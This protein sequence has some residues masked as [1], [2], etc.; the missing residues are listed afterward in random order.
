[1]SAPEG[2]LDTKG[3]WDAAA[4]FP[5]QVE[6]AAAQTHSLIGLP[7]HD[8]IEN[9]VVLGMGG[10][11]IA[12]DLMTAL[13]GPFMPVPIVVTKGYEPPSFVGPQTLC[14]ALSF[15]GDTEETIEAAQTAA[16]AGARMVVIA[17]G[18]Q[19]A[20]L[21]RSWDAPLIGLPDGIPYPRA[22]L[23][24]M[25]IP[26]MLVLE[27]TG[28]FPGASGWIN[29]AV[30]QLKVRRD[31][32]LKDDNPARDLARRIGRT[33]PIIYGGGG[34]G[35]TAALRWKNEMN[36]N[37]KV[38]AFIHTVPELMHNEICGWGQHGDI[39]RQVFS[40]VLLRHDHEHP[41]IMRRF[42][43]VRQWTEE[44]VAGV[45]EVRAEGDGPLAQAFD[46]MFYGTITSLWMAA[47]EG[48]DPG[49]ITV[50]EE[51]KAALA[52]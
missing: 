47:A 26:T 20:R 23:G 13:A 16:F 35:A 33:M 14:F 40:L 46:L 42:D 48:V 8:E 43:L 17:K 52:Q 27:Q 12:G 44:V 19:L 4:A 34:L 7:S 41:Q 5:E 18:G 29:L 39:T 45:E 31:E 24:A 15:S 9:V 22:A 37:P 3:M 2:V 38:P 49:P 1:V 30:Q 6:D 51:I 10:S 32:L 25:S 50:L 36:E 11:G 28:L 21:A